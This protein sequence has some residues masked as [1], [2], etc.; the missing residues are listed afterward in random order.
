MIPIGNDLLGGCA[1]LVSGV[2]QACRQWM[3]EPHS[4]SEGAPRCD[5]HHDDCENMLTDNPGGDL[6]LLKHRGRAIRVGSWEFAA[7]R[8]QV[9]GEERRDEKNRQADRRFH[10]WT[11]AEPARPHFTWNLSR[12]AGGVFFSRNRNVP[13]SRLGE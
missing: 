11:L 13:R 4:M 1:A 9:A 5:H 3:I 10:G 7:T 8:K 6:R 2:T 12:K